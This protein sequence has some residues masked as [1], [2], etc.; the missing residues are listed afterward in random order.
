MENNIDVPQKLK[1][2]T[3]TWSSNS[4]SGNIS[5]ENKNT[6][7]EV[8]A[9]PCS[10]Q[11]SFTIAKT[12]KQP[13]CL[14]RDEWIK[15]LWYINIHWNVFQLLKMEILPFGTT[16]MDLNSI[17]LS[18]ISQRKTNTVWSHLYMKSKKKKKKPQRKKPKLIERDQVCSYQGREW[19]QGGNWKTWSKCINFQLRG[20]LQK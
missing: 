3:T 2:G 12:W 4:T 10:E 19:G 14:L 5:E 18:E 8:S 20:V 11:H 13:K 6:V 15:K 7:K 17:T 9:P 1:N 16:Q